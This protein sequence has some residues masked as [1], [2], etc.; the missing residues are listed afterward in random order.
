MV[1]GMMTVMGENPVYKNKLFSHICKAE[2][3]KAGGLID[4][5]GNFLTYIATLDVEKALIVSLKFWK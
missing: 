3:L 2:Y 4:N 5:V 1:D